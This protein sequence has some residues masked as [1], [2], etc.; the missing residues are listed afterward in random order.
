MS[1]HRFLHFEGVVKAIGKQRRR[2]F[3]KICGAEHAGV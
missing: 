2:Y 1:P 3:P